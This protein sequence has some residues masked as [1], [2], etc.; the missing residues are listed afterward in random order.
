MRKGLDQMLQM[1]NK[2]EE[3]KRVYTYETAVGRYSTTAVTHT[4][5]QVFASAE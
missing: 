2:T 1:E 5:N 3:K 4:G